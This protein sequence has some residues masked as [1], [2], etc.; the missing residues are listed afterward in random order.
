MNLTL[1]TKV[2]VYKVEYFRLAI[3]SF[4]R[5]F[6]TNHFKSNIHIVPISSHSFFLN[7]WLRFGGINLARVFNGKV[8]LFAGVHL[9][10]YRNDGVVARFYRILI[11]KP[12]FNVLLRF[13]VKAYFV[14]N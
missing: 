2:V 1:L 13:N 6:G 14:G 3:K 12:V 10:D 4:I 7:C 5:F 9:Y 11:V 8:I